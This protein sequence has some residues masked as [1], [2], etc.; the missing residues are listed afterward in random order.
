MLLIAYY[1]PPLGGSGALRPLKLAKYLPEFGWDPIILTVKNPD[2]YYAL[3]PGLLYEL[4]SS[5][6]VKKSLMVKSAWIYKAL[7]PLRIPSLDKLLRIYLF[8]PDEQVGWIPFAYLTAM[9]IVRENPIDAIYST[10]G[11]MSCHVIANRIKKKTDLPWIADFRDEWFEAPNLNMPTRFHRNF[12]YSLENSVIQNA[13]K[14]ITMA[15]IFEKLLSK[16][17]RDKEKFVT[18]T[19]GFD[20]EDRTETVSQW[21]RRDSSKKF[22]ISFTGLFYDS[23]RPQEFVRAVLELVADGKIP[24][25]KLMVRFVG[26]NTPNDINLKDKYRVFEF[27]GFVPR[28]QA[29]RYLSESDALLLLLSKE[30]GKD[31]IPSKTFEYMASGKPI[32]ALVPLDGTVAEIINTTKTGIVVDFEDVEGI[33]RAF[34]KIYQAWE[35][36]KSEMISPDIRLLNKYNQKKLAEKFANIISQSALK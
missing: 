14:I 12:H 5:I 35:Q 16:H 17:S 25:E 21:Y 24:A 34:V 6:V 33:K 31:V 26:A 22:T 8:H 4:S 10:S 36:Q 30:R 13:D 29:L 27:T 11:P 19:G 15:P 2:W 9:K 18:I 1:F 20:P 3:D 28:L 32:L 23:F 7:N